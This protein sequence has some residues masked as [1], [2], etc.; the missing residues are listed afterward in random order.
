MLLRRVPGW[1]RFGLVLGI[2]LGCS[3]DGS[4]PTSPIVPGGAGYRLVV[5]ASDTL[6]GAAGDTVRGASVQVLGPTNL[7]VSG[8]RVQWRVLQGGGHLLRSATTTDQDGVAT[9]AWVLGT[10]LSATQVLSSELPLAHDDRRSGG[11]GV[12]PALIRAMAVLPSGL[13]PSVGDTSHAYVDTIGALLGKPVHLRVHLADGRPV[14]GATIDF[15]VRRGGGRIGSTTVV[16]DTQGRAATTWQFGDT[17]GTQELAA[18]VRATAGG[19]VGSSV[20]RAM[21]LPGSPVEILPPGDTLRF[22]A[23][24]DTLRTVQFRDRAGNIFPGTAIWTSQS[25][26]VV[27]ALGEDGITPVAEGKGLITMRRGSLVRTVPVVVAQASASVAFDSSTV[28]LHSLGARSAV[29]AVVRDRLGAVIPAAQLTWLSLDSSTAV[30]DGQGIVRATGPGTTQLAATYQGIT[31]RARVVVVQ[32][33]ASI[34]VTPAVDTLALDSVRAPTVVVRDSG[35][36]PIPSP[37]LSVTQ[38][39]PA[40]LAVDAAGSLTATLPGPTTLTYRA[41]SVSTTI[42]R[43]VEGSAILVSGQRVTTPQILSGLPAFTI[44]NGRVR[45]S[46]STNMGERASVFMEVRIGNTWHPAS[47]PRYGDW[48]YITSSIITTPNQIAIIENTPDR[49]GVRWNY[50]DHWF[51][52]QMEGFPASILPSPY[53][54]KRTVW[55]AKQENGYYSWVDVVNDLHMNIVEHETGFGGLWGPATIRTNRLEIRTDTLANTIRYNGNPGLPVMGSLVDAAEF[56]RDND[57]VRR[58]LV[59]V[60]EAPFITPVFPGW[61]YGSVYRYASPSR[62]FGVYMYATAVGTGPSASQVCGAAWAN[63]PFPLR[64][65]T[66]AEVASCGPA[67]P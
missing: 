12:L 13:Q 46:W 10:D 49:I 63:A 31:A 51:L 47:H 2:L 67:A 54:F 17:A 7:P 27:R 14:V 24:G 11:R 15:E 1:T 4:G 8:V 55:L 30:V 52:P 23:I 28:T 57:P 29:R 66:P 18:T 36:F 61:G 59:P 21:V 9:A 19:P 44:T 45:I 53:P 22:D 40:I 26:S 3:G 58:L 37:P 60:P 25:P 34:S 35:G 62:S 64:P 39:D 41:G 38:T 50:D 56:V 5:L 16:T 32:V 48:V 43:V 42:D 6:R 20:I 65:L 33:P